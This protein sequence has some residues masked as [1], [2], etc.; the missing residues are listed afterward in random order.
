MANEG[1]SLTKAT[2]DK[3]RPRGP[4]PSPERRKAALEQAARDAA[5]TREVHTDPASWVRKYVSKKDVGREPKPPE[6]PIDRRF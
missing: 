3:K 2:Y 5:F 1:P 6:P 4:T